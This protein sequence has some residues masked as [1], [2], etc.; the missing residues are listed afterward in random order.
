MYVYRY[1]LYLFPV[2]F[3]PSSSS[4]VILRLSF[5]SLRYNYVY[6]VFEADIED[7]FPGVAMDKTILCAKICCSSM[8]CTERVL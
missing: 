3:L 5:L 1:I 7:I 8:L 6:K 4:L 2:S